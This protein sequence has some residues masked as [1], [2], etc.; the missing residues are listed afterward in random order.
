MSVFKIKSANECIYDEIS[1]G[2]VMLRI[3]PGDVPAARARTARIWHGG[4]ETNVAE[5]LSYCFGLRTAVVTALVDDGIGRKIYSGCCTVG[6]GPWYLCAGDSWRRDYGE[7]GRRGEGSQTRNHRRRDQRPEINGPVC[8]CFRLIT[9]HYRELKSIA[10]KSGGCAFFPSH[11]TSRLH[12][13]R[14]V[15]CAN[16][17]WNIICRFLSGMSK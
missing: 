17:W 12:S 13:G 7:T 3:D 14:L 16:G 8:P 15:N 4:G 9:V 11:T 1:L 6:C 2:E 5:G 10:R